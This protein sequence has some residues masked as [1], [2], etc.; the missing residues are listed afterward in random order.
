MQVKPSVGSAVADRSG[1]DWYNRSMLFEP[2]Y[3]VR[4][5]SFYLFELVLKFG[6]L[7]EAI[8]AYNIG[9][10]RLRN[11]LKLKKEPPKVYLA[12]VMKKYRALK[13]EYDI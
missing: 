11:I 10:T 6:D 9:E 13:E 8:T 1:I 5:G 4:L 12:K 2:E 7:K 3:N